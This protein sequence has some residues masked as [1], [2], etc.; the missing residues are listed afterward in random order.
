[1]VST[2]PVSVF[3]TSS[4]LTSPLI[5]Q[6][7]LSQLSPFQIIHIASCC[8][9]N[10]GL[11][12]LEIVLPSSPLITFSSPSLCTLFQPSCASP[13]LHISSTVFC[14]SPRPS[15]SPSFHHY[16]TR[17]S[18]FTFTSLENS[19][20]FRRLA[21]S[22]C[23]QDSSVLLLS[24]SQRYLFSRLSFCCYSPWCFSSLPSRI[25]PNKPI[26]FRCESFSLTFPDQ[27]KPLGRNPT[28]KSL[29]SFFPQV[30]SHSSRLQDLSFSKHLLLSCPLSEV[31]ALAFAHRVVH[32]FQSPGRHGESVFCLF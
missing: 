7:V 13:S 27:N 4:S 28:P 14:K 19:L 11:P 31:L 24:A 16:L 21:P 29:K 22:N 10:R 15:L 1:M 6:R 20:P 25:S 23:H 17:L 5:R 9:P 8:K 32:I 26:I 30:L 18:G 12:S 3:C 2:S